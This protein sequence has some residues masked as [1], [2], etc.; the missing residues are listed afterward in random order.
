MLK[1]TA[2]A[3]MPTASWRAPAKTKLRTVESE[4]DAPRS[5]NLVLRLTQ[6]A[7]VSLS[8]VSAVRLSPGC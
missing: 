7:S 4:T 1:V 2:A 8:A 6:L 5:V 3:A